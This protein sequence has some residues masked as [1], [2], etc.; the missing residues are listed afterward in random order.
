MIGV[1]FHKTLPLFRKE[2][3]Q[4]GLMRAM[5][6]E[7][8]CRGWWAGVLIPWITCV[9]SAFRTN[10]RTK[11]V[12]TNRTRQRVCADGKKLLI[13]GRTKEFREFI[14]L[15]Y[16]QPRLCTFLWKWFGKYGEKVALATEG[17][18]I[19]LNKFP[20]NDTNSYTNFIPYHTQ[21]DANNH[22]FTN[23][24]LKLPQMHTHTHTS[25]IHTRI[26]TNYNKLS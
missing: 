12:P 20:Q 15:F 11:V 13:R 8:R 5:L 19:K 4:G 10:E 26:S 14:Y 7:K 25:T 9:Q 1:I 2:R 18:D 17:K 16:G 3:F 22:K 24:F 6:C 21:I 23:K